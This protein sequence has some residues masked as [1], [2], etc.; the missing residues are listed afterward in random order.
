MLAPTKLNFDTSVSTVES[1]F[2]PFVFIIFPVVGIEC[3]SP[4]VRGARMY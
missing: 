4:T 2:P 3:A 1:M